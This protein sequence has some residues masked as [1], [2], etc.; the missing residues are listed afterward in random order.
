MDNTLSFLNLKGIVNRPTYS[1]QER[2]NLGCE[3][4]REFARYLCKQGNLDARRFKDN[5]PTLD[6]KYD[7]THGDVGIFIN[8]EIIFYYDLKL[9]EFGQ[10]P[11]Y[12]GAITIHSIIR[13]TCDD[14]HFYVCSNSD[15]SDFCVISSKSAKKY[16][17]DTPK[18]LFTSKSPERNKY[19][20]T[21]FQPDIKEMI[22]S[23]YMYNK[24]GNISALDIVMSKEYPE[25]A[26]N[27]S[28]LII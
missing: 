11:N 26:I 2:I 12:Y 16:F 10:N 14:K 15:G 28:I 7:L 5:N 27:K 3:Q 20:I 22:L 18:C 19:I 13:F 25:L 9:A 4:E 8:N 17:H 23:K 6:N 1:K 24:Y 21:N